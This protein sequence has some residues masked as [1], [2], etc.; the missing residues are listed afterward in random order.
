MQVKINGSVVEIPDGC[1]LEELMLAR[2][3]SARAAITELNGEV[4]RPERRA[5]TKLNPNDKLEIIHILGG[6]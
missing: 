2:K 6:G 1:S 4:I 5:K 3:V